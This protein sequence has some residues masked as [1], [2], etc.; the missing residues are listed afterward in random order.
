MS[1]LWRTDAVGNDTYVQRT[2]SSERP[3]NRFATADQD[4]LRR[5]MRG[6]P[7]TVNSMKLSGEKDA[8]IH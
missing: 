7:T 5:T 3:D 2:E 4:P 6:G 1:I 8:V